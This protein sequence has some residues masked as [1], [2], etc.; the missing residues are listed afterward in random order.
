[1]KTLQTQRLSFSTQ[2]YNVDIEPHQSIRIY[3]TAENRLRYAKDESGRF[4]PESYAQ[5]FDLTFR[6]GD[7]AVYGSYNL[8]YTGKIVAIGPHTVTIETSLTG[9]R[10]NKRLDLWSFADR[11]WDYD[12]EKIARDNA[13]ETQY[14]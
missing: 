13:I 14:I 2:I 8:T 12:G 3:G 6:L 7:Y 4:H 1:M 10:P 5:P 9:G 11:N